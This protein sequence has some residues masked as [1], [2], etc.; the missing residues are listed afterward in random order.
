MFRF[1]A[2]NEGSR[3]TGL[4]G[5]QPV[6]S[7]PVEGKF[8]HG[9]QSVLAVDIAQLI[10]MS[11]ADLD[12]LYLANPGGEIPRGRGNGALLLGGGAAINEAA[13]W[14]VRQVMWQGKVFDPDRGELRN[15]LTP[16]GIKAIVAKVYSGPSW[17]DAKPCIV[18]DYSKTS[19]VAHWIRDEIRLVAPGL[20]LGV[21]Y[22]GKV[23]VAYFA[24]SFDRE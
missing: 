3:D 17:S 13:A 19:T 16:F 23:K 1:Q 18:L 9:R 24:L 2:S 22:L 6:V 10:K 5:N 7:A 8:G 4:P 21:A 20:Y 15:L 12:R 14:Y 11:R